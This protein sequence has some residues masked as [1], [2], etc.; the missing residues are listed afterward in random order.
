MRIPLIDYIQAAPEIRAEFD[1]QVEHHGRITHMKRT[2]LHSLPAYRALME[3]YPMRDR[4]QPFLGERLTVLF[5][6]AISAETDCLICS[7]FFRRLLIEAGENPDDL[8]LNEPE[9]TVLAFGRQLVKDPNSVD[10]TL[11]EKLA[12]TYR[13]HPCT[14]LP[15]P[16]RSYK[17][18]CNRPGARK[19]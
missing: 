3:W 19:K 5:A 17:P 8:V 15:Y 2:L 4:V 18:A 6:H 9:Q 13:I 10:D 14:W 11:Y 16:V 7:T 1:Y 12:A